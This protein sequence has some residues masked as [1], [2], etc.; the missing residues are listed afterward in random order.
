MS[1]KFI[2][3]ATLILIFC[4]SIEAQKSSNLK[5]DKLLGKVKTV[6]TERTWT[7]KSVE[8]KRV[9][10][11]IEIYDQRGNKTE[12]NAYMGSDRPLRTSFTYDDKGNVT[13]QIWYDS[14]DQPEVNTVYNYNAK[15]NLVEEFSS[16]K[17]H[18]VF[19][20]DSRNNKKSQQV[21][22]VA[23]NEGSRMFGAVEKTVR[24]SYD[25]LNRLI[26][27]AS[28]SPNGSR[29]WNPELQAHRI[30]YV[31]DDKGQITSQ[32]V[33]NDDNILRTKTD[34]AY[35]SS[36]R[37]VNEILFTGK[38]RITEVFLY[39]YEADTQDNWTVQTKNKQISLRGKCS[40]SKVETVYRNIEYY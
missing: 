28:Y 22:D 15:G 23:E 35:D 8:S 25:K 18:V 6:R 40:Y 4:N 11:T 21:F 26:Q 27:I 31:Y 36:G 24:Y 39:N 32:S 1:I 20:Y 38:D 17:I 10:M 33:F 7:T 16:N 34:Y 30:I 9:L 13:K 2:I 3:F 12:W 37:V 14:A 29:V 5:I 19:T